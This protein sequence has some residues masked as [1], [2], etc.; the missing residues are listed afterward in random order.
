VTFENIVGGGDDVKLVASEV[1][2]TGKRAMMNIAEHGKIVTIAEGGS[3]DGTWSLY[4]IIHENTDSNGGDSIPNPAQVW[5]FTGGIASRTL[6][7]IF[8]AKHY[9]PAEWLESIAVDF[10]GRQTPCF[11]FSF[12]NVAGEPINDVVNVILASKP[13]EAEENLLSD[14]FDDE[15]YSG[16]TFERGDSDCDCERCISRESGDAV[17]IWKHYLL[18]YAENGES[19]SVDVLVYAGWKQKS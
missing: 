14:I 18:H 11:K 10:D 15:K 5:F 2:G 7:E 19:K 3:V 13:G 16:V 17:E 12:E 9:V 1:L 6:D 4:N 8:D